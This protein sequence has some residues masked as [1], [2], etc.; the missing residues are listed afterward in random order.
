MS[1]NHKPLD[2]INAAD[3]QA[4]KDNQMPEGKTIEYKEI[5]PGKTDSDRKEFLADVSSFANAAGGNLIF[6]VRAKSGL[7]VEVCG[8]QTTDADAEVLRLESMIRDSVQPRIPGVSVE[9]VPLKKQQG[10]KTRYTKTKESTH[11]TGKWNV[12]CAKF[13]REAVHLATTGGK[14]GMYRRLIVE[15]GWLTREPSRITSVTSISVIHRS[16]TTGIDRSE[17]AS[18]GLHGC[19]PGQH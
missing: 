15:I 16:D 11:L 5:L 8:L 4:L 13:K 7:P 10:D 12:Y 1:L 2:S 14:G 6:G 9:A 3:L 19:A 18:D 17:M